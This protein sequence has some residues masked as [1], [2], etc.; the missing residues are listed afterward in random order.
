[1]GAV[2]WMA[3]A[4]VV[5]VILRFGLLFG[6]Q[7]ARAVS[8]AP[9]TLTLGAILDVHAWFVAVQ[10]SSD[11]SLLTVV[12]VVVLLAAGYWTA[13]AT[14]PESPVAGFASGAT[15]TVGYLALLI[16]LVVAMQILG[17]SAGGESGL[18]QILAV[19]ITGIVYPVVFGGV[20][21][22]IASRVG[23]VR[24]PASAADR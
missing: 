7:F 6:D 9:I 1:M 10:L 5:H 3:V 18:G 20:G 17:S 8:G 2:A 19:A 24:A 16:V 4:V 12:P 11:L 13:S 15:V 22:A 21:G 14:G 23:R